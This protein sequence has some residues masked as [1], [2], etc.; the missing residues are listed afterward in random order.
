MLNMAVDSRKSI[1]IVDDEKDIR[2]LIHELIL[3]EFGIHVNIITAGDGLEAINKINAQ[4]FHCIVTDIRM[5][6][7]DGK[8][9]IKLV[10]QNP[11]NEQTPVV[12]VSG[13]E[14]EKVQYELPF[15]YY[16]SKPFDAQM[17]TKLVG[18]LMSD[19]TVKHKLSA[20]VL[21]L[22]IKNT[23]EIMKYQLGR[24]DIKV[25]EPK[26]TEKGFV[27]SNQWMNEIKVRLSGK[28]INEF[29][30][31]CEELALNALFEKSTALKNK[32]FTLANKI[33]RSLSVKGEL[34]DNVSLKF[35][36][37][38]KRK[39]F[40]VDSKGILFPISTDDIK[41]HVYAKISS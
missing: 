21:N 25:G 15:V 4:K 29:Y 35:S 19:G 3:E 33:I 9:F 41:V 37:S 10:R 5:P 28:V 40:K 32:N 8:T 12:V 18:D 17:F 1:L 27:F 31:A 24:D 23:K 26:T 6:R 7:K 39:E 16:F 30:I 11:Y 38:E 14:S 13:T 22:V 20:T 34:I 36:Q 2:E